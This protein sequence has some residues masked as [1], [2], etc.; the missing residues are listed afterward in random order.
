MSN[1]DADTGLCIFK[2]RAAAVLDY[3]VD[4]TDWLESGDTI[5]TSVWT[6]EP[7]IT[8]DSE[9]ETG[10]V[11]TIWLSGGMAGRSYRVTNQ[12]V[13][14]AGRTNDQPMIIEVLR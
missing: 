4:W 6:V 13:T 2:K 5:Q 12:I 7:G 3:N 14:T 8:Q 9:S 1:Q 10:Q 11:A